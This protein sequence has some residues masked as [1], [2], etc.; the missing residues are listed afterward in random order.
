MMQKEKPW[1]KPWGRLLCTAGCGVALLLA[2]FF[3]A[4][5][6]TLANGLWF[7]MS[8][9]SDEV[10]YNRQLAAV[11]AQGGPQ[12]YFGYN[13][14]HALIGHYSTW[15]PFVIWLYAIPGILF[16]TG[17]NTVFWCNMVFSLLCW[18]VFTWRMDWKHQLT[19]ALGLFCAWLPLR[20]IFTGTSEP[21]HF[22]LLAVVLAASRAIA[23]GKRSGTAAALLACTV[24][25]VIRPYGVVL[26]LFPLVFG[27]KGNFRKLQVAGT[28]E[29]PQQPCCFRSGE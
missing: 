11:L 23:D 21:L 26:F 19:F 1:Q 8:T 12:G 4:Y 28:G 6:S 20:Q 18:C 5:R 13:E 24:E 2:A 29:W 22:F 14:N 27:R 10:M 16:G 9:N 25:T 3:I 7:P 15:G 17:Y